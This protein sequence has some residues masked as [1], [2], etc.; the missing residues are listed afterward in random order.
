MSSKQMYTK[1]AIA[2]ILLSVSC[3]LGDGV[4]SAPE[5]CYAGTAHVV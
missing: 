2:C 4:Q 5:V 1:L 3:S